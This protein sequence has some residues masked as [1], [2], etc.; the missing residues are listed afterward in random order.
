MRNTVFLFVGLFMIWNGMT[1][2]ESVTFA[3]K[4]GKELKMTI[5]EADAGNRQPETI[6]YSSFAS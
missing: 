3:V 1:A 5:Y 2:Q 4:D 6:I